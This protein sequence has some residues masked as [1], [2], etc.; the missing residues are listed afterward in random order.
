MS[1]CNKDE[2]VSAE[3][4]VSLQRWDLGD[5]PGSAEAAVGPQSVHAANGALYRKN[6]GAGQELRP[7]DHRQ[8]DLHTVRTHFQK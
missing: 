8:A 2:S 3:L 7:P 5:C 4:Y 1:E 6:H